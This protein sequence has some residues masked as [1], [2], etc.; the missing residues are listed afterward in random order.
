MSFL[1]IKGLLSEDWVKLEFASTLG[2]ISLQWDGGPK[3]SIH[4]ESTRMLPA[5][6]F[7][8]LFR[9]PRME[10]AKFIIEILAEGYRREVTIPV[11][12]K[13]DG[14][15]GPTDTLNQLPEWI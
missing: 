1:P 5:L 13:V 14:E 3:Y 6:N 8:R 11:T 9:V 15:P 10:P 4:G 2:I 7:E 12:F